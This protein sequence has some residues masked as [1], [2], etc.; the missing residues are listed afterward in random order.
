MLTAFSSPCWN[1]GSEFQVQA[2]ARGTLGRVYPGSRSSEKHSPDSACSVDYSSSCLSSPE[3]PTEDSESTEPL[4]VDGISS[5]LEEPAEG[6]EEEE[7]EG[8]TASYAL[9]E[10][11]P[12]TP[13]QEQFL[14]QHFETLANGAA[15]GA[16]V[17]VP[18][19]SES[20]SISSRFLLKVQTR[21]LR[22]KDPPP[23]SSS[24]GSQASQCCC[25][26]LSRVLSL[27]ARGVFMPGSGL[28]SLAPAL[29]GFVPVLLS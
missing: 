10:G 2:P 7:E 15:P 18:E 28:T 6:D 8:G 16:P 14:K 1:P 25:P 12:R 19:R 4:S 9:Q 27:R 3:H 22:Y 13:D 20:R 26:L 11:S 21:P 17:Q 5:D 23:H 24:S 29:S